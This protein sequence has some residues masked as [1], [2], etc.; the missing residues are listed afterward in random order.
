MRTLYVRHDNELYEFVC[1]RKPGHTNKIQIHSLIVF[2]GG[3]DGKPVTM[4]EVSQLVKDKIVNE[5]HANF[6]NSSK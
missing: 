5:I 2:H 1:S 4:D 3:N 6:N